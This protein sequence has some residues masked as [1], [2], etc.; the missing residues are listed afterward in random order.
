MSSERDRLQGWKEIANFLGRDERTAKRW[1]K[2]R[3]L[4]VRRIP[5][6]GRANVYI[7]TAE[8]EEW[9]AAGPG[10]AGT[11]EAAETEPAETEEVEA[12][13]PAELVEAFEPEEA[14]PAEFA[15][16][17]NRWR[18]GLWLGGSLAAGVLL[19]VGAG[20]ARAVHVARVKTEAVAAKAPGYRSP[21]AGVDEL[22]LQGV[23]FYEERTP[24]SLA[25]A[26]KIFSDVIALDDKDA[27]AYTGLAETYLLEREYADMTPTEAYLRA[28]DAAE[29]AL[30]LDP[31]LAEA[32][33]V[34]GFIAFF[35]DFDPGSATEQ[36]KSA[37]A[38]DPD[39]VLAH[40]WYG[41]MLTHQGLYARGLEE[42]TVAERL[43]PRSA[44]VISSR[45]FALGL[46]GQRP[47]ALAILKKM[48]L[49]DP[50]EPSPPRI[51][52]RLALQPPRDLDGYFNAMLQFERVRNNVAARTALEEDRQ[53]LHASGEKAMWEGVVAREQKSGFSETHPS[54][55]LAEAEA[56]LG[57]RQEALGM[58]TVMA[59]H[60]ELAMI[61]LRMNPL[62][63]ELRGEA[64]FQ[65]MLQELGLSSGTGAAR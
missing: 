47:E 37:L 26:R 44:A 8:L 7:I 31:K 29:H 65:R 17:K 39:C 2:Q 5:G 4:P 51:A 46:N 54:Y 62:F 63:A 49:D 35:S 36:F 61:G 11:A 6:A 32:H 1:E 52:A 13:E 56:Q 3:G 43:E 33:A 19:L 9:L 21:K 50:R 14:R 53:T 24:A 34:M 57:R 40:H 55:A 23:Y 59:E 38:L 25:S 48:M 28:R 42:L 45:A 16:T 41:S 18:R 30:R 15:E 58:L 12:V 27:P 22:Y 20:V 10:P 64:S 60:R